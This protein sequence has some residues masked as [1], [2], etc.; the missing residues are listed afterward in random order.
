MAAL[1]LPVEATLQIAGVI[2]ATV[3][4]VVT[5]K[6]PDDPDPAAVHPVTGASLIRLLL[7]ALVPVAILVL[8]AA[9]RGAGP[10]SPVPLILLGVASAHWATVFWLER[11][12]YQSAALIRVASFALVILSFGAAIAGGMQVTGDWL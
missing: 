12:R 11:H 6:D 5:L 2:A 4:L 7:Y 1:P 8:A 10:G 3:G 9:F